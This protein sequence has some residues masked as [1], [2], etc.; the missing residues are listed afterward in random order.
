M[1]VLPMMCAEGGKPRL[2]AA[3]YTGS[4]LVDSFLNEAEWRVKIRFRVIDFN[5]HWFRLILMK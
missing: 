1:G 3:G 2:A 5:R 4:W